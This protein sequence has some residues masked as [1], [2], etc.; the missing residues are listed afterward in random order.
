MKEPSMLVASIATIL[1]AVFLSAATPSS[2]HAQSSTV[3]PRTEIYVGAPLLFR[4]GSGGAV[5]PV[6]GTITFNVN[7]WF[8]ISGDVGVYI[9]EVLYEKPLYTFLGGP[10]FSVRSGKVKGFAHSLVGGAH[11]GCADFSD[12]RGCLGVVSPSAV[13]GGGLDIRPRDRLSLRAQ[14]DVLLTRFRNETQAFLRLSFG[15]VIPLGGD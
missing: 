11:S 15:V 2:A 7:S 4:E 6:E 8:G 9:G 3:A 1:C 12:T 10:V 13:F 5:L 14:A